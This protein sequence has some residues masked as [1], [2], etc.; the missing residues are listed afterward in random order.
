M[1]GGSVWRL[2]MLIDMMKIQL[3]IAI[4]RYSFFRLNYLSQYCEIAL[5]RK[6]FQIIV[7]LNNLCYLRL[8]SL[9]IR[10]MGSTKNHI[11]TREHIEL[12]KLFKALAHPARIA[13][14]ENL[15]KHKRL[16]GTD[17]KFYVQLAQSTISEHVRILEDAG[18]LQVN[19]EGNK[20]YYH[21]KKIAL[22]QITCYIQYLVE[23]V[24]EKFQ[25]GFNLFQKRDPYISKLYGRT[26][27]T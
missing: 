6:V 12:A 10:P 2:S 7:K 24:D 5:L 13:I 20:T 11:H 17:L 26:Y 22:D 27:Q 18:I 19:V 16:N 23:Q 3:L 9:T 1:A 15:L 8:S 4:L 21:V 14:V 25:L